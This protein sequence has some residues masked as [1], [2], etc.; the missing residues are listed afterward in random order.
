MIAEGFVIIDGGLFLR[1]HLDNLT[2]AREPTTTGRERWVNGIPLG[3][4]FHQVESAWRP[5]LLG[6]GLEIARRL[7]AQ[8]ADLC[9]DYRMQS[10]IWLQ[11]TPVTGSNASATIFSP[12]RM[13]SEDDSREYDFAT[14]NLTV[15]R[16]REPC[17][18]PW[19]RPEHDTFYPERIPQPRLTL[20]NGHVISPAPPPG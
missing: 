12:D 4:P 10:Y 16:V 9:G 19:A 2:R 14:G 1:T 20:S 7:L 13:E 17:D 5:Q 3:V 15:Y 11:P 18:D 6:W 8:A